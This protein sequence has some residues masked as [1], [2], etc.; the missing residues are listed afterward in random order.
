MF[1]FK[2]SNFQ[3]NAAKGRVWN[4]YCS[5]LNTQCSMHSVQR[6]L[7]TVHSIQWTVYCLHYIQFCTHCI[8]CPLYSAQCLL[9]FSICVILM[10]QSAG[11]RSEPVLDRKNKWDSP[12]LVK[13][14]SQPENWFH[15]QQ[16]PAFCPLYFHTH[17]NVSQF[18][19]VFLSSNLTLRQFNMR[20]SKVTLNSAE[21]QFLIFYMFRWHFRGGRGKGRWR[22]QQNLF[23]LFE[24]P[25]Y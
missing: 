2:G 25:L 18:L 12:E 13:I 5:V 7:Y 22:S 4:A 11:T 3:I 1:F 6:V 10:L 24:R 23:V 16:S 21:P 15:N 8:Q 14:H 20:W 19:K 17:K 9:P